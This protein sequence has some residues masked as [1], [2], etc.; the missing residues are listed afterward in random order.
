MFAVLATVLPTLTLYVLSSRR[1]R[2]ALGDQVTQE[3]RGVTTEAAWEIDQWLGERQFDLL[4]AATSYA[5]AENLARVQGNGGQA[6]SQLRDYLNVVRGR[7]ADCDALVVSDARGRAVTGSG[8]RMSGVQFSVDRLS[9][10][11]TGGVLVG[12][13]YWDGGLGRAAM[14]LAVP[15]R[16]ADGRYVGA[17]SAKLSLRPIADILQRLAPGDGGDLFVMT[18]TG[19]LILRA[20]VSSA[21]L[22]R[23]K[24]AAEVTQPLL[25]K[26]GA[27]VSYKRADGREVLGTLRRVPA[28][29]WAVV[30]EVPPAEALR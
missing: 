26:E 11:R 25:D 5:V 10:L 18:E 9:G 23:T 14:A 19:R 16:Q 2:G 20:R 13:A 22:M 17:L 4:V 15:V 29:H 21:E 12:D 27:S 3:L 24:L 7:C 1:D 30:V 6:L 8:G 28:L